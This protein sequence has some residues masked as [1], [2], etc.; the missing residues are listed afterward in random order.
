[1]HEWMPAVDGRADADDHCGVR[2]RAARDSAD[3]L[4]RSLP[5]AKPKGSVEAPVGGILRLRSGQAPVK[6]LAD[7]Q[8]ACRQVY[9]TRHDRSSS[10]IDT[11]GIQK[12]TDKLRG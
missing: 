5:R 10:V 9:G 4:R 2:G 3:T 11:G 7:S 8:W 1:M 6:T 12:V